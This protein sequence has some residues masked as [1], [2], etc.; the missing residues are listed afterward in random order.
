MNVFKK[1]TE[2]KVPAKNYYIVAIGS[3][4]TIGLVLLIRVM[5]LNYKENS[6]KNSIFNEK[7]VTQIHTEDFDFALNEMPEGILYVSYTGNFEVYSIEKK[8]YR[9]MKRKDLLDKVIYWDVTNTKDYLKI[10]QEKYPNIKSQIT[11]APMLIYIKNGQAEEA[12]SSEFRTI[13]SV[14]FDKLVDKYEIK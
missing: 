14:V 4:I 12:M 2:R 7:G 11:N 10:L 8:L 6:T 13:D 9:E 1:L 5:Y 3:L